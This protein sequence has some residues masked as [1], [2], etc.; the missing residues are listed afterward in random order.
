[1]THKQSVFGRRQRHFTSQC[2][3]TGSDSHSLRWH[4]CKC[5]PAVNLWM[6]V[7][8]WHRPPDHHMLVVRCWRRPLEAGEKK[9]IL[10]QHLELFTSKVTSHHAQGPDS[11]SCCPFSNASFETILQ[12]LQSTR[13]RDCKIYSEKPKGFCLHLQCEESQRRRRDLIQIPGD[14]MVP[15]DWALGPAGWWAAGSHDVS[16]LW[17]CQIKLWP[18]A[19]S[20]LSDSKAEAETQAD[21]FSLQL[22]E[23]T[24]LS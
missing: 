4:H 18:V 10:N 6:V 12:R 14:S 1:M 8:A 3:P 13:L 24:F 16:P 2:D 15:T 21:H 19:A 11:T 22:K 17:G 7:T 9:K 23:F 5:S 20:W